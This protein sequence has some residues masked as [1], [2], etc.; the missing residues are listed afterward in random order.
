MPVRGSFNGTIVQSDADGGNPCLDWQN[1]NI[2]SA[3]NLQLNLSNSPRRVSPVRLVKPLLNVK[4]KKKKV[5]KP[6]GLVSILEA[7]LNSGDSQQVRLAKDH[8]QIKRKNKASWDSKNS[9]NS[10][11][12]HFRF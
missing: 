5:V 6:T 8:L 12:K 9:G 10:S 2:Q 11:S 3:L 7:A 1:Q 4:V